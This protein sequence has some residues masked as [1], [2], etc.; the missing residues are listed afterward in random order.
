MM[1]KR[2]PIMAC[3]VF[4]I[5]GSSCRK[6][7]SSSAAS[8]RAEAP[9]SSTRVINV[10][11]QTIQPSDFE[12]K[13]LLTGEVEA[14]KKVTVSSEIAGKLQ[15]LG[16]VEGK[17]AVQG[18]VVA[19]IN[20]QLLAAQRDQAMANY[21]LSKAQESWQHRTQNKQVNLA[22]T[23]YSNSAL[24][25]QRQRQLLQEQV[26]SKQSFDNAENA[27]KNARLQ[28]E[29]QQLNQSANTELN[30]LQTAVASANL[31][32]AQVNLEKTAVVSPM[33][34]FVNKVYVETGEFINPGMPIAD[35]VQINPV[36][37]TVGVPERDISRIR[38]GDQVQVRLDAYP[39]QVFTGPVIF[40][41]AVADPANRTFPI[42]IR[43]QNPDLRLRPGMI[44][45]VSM[46]RERVQNTLVIPLDAVIEQEK[47]RIVFVVQQGIAV[48]REI[49]I[50]AKSGTQVRVLRGLKP[51]EQLIIFGH[52]NLI[53]GEK[54]RV[55]TAP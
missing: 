35:L 29:L 48:R 12:E 4:L 27:L 14:W 37:V 15:W 54:V 38:L 42:K 10:R 51:G 7:E 55:T 6:P 34:G 23:N 36:K 46:I 33:S 30:Q 52:R 39:N 53:G 9:R 47:G 32:L 31:R 3:L 20:G 1:S 22:E 18:A 13:L 40:I 25:F 26:V 11:T 50:G 19:R 17:T 49:E 28:L 2:M 8:A 45:H 43:L 44:A 21:R 24:N 5:L 41:G 16:L